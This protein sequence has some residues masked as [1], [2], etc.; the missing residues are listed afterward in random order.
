MGWTYTHKDEGESVKE[1]FSREF[2]YA[3]DKREVSLLD[4]AVI[5]LREAYM[6]FKDVN[7]VNGTRQVFAVVCLLD[8]RP[9]DHWNFGY[10][11]MDESM[12][13][14]YY[15]CPEK[16]LRVLSPTTNEY[17]I[18]WRKKCWKRLSRR[19]EI[20]KLKVGDILEFEKPIA[21]GGGWKLQ[22]LQVENKKRGL[23]KNPD[24]GWMSFRLKKSFLENNP[25]V[26]KAA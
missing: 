25:F 17:A 9:K 3:N 26:V 15:N 7:L 1:F 14:C 12:G 11:D 22:R 21:F 16:I 4:C 8:Y 24:G 5:R 20:A 19:K 2:G 6:A 18:K 23:F 13:P 10:K